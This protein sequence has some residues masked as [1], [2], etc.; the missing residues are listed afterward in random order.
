MIL[1][2]ENNYIENDNL[3]KSYKSYG[4]NIN[5]LLFL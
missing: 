3:T 5:I 1:E 2:I 4:F